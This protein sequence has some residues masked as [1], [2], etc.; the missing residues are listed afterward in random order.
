MQLSLRRVPSRVALLAVLAGVA[1]RA[2][3]D[4]GVSTTATYFHESGGGLDMDVFTP[5]AR[6]RLDIDDTLIVGAGWEADI[7]SG[8]SV[9]IVD[10]PAGA[11]VDVIT[12]AT[13]LT[14]VRH[15][16]GGSLELRGDTT[17]ISAAYTY[18]FEEDYRSHGITLSGRAELFERNTTLEIAWARGFDSACDLAQPRAQEA[19][20]RARLPSSDGC[21]SSDEAE[22]RTTHDID[23][24]TFQ[25]AWTQVWTPVLATQATITA[26]LLHGFQANPYRAVWLGR[27]S[28]QEH[29]P[30]NRARYAL[31]LEARLWIDPLLGAL[32]VFGRVYRDSWAVRSLTAELAWE[33][34][35]GELLRLRAR[36]R[37]Y[38]Q[39][40][41]IFWSD[42]YA[43]DPAGQYFTGDRELS[44]MSSWTFGGRL[45]LGM[46]ADEDGDVLGFLSALDFVFKGDLIMAT[47]SDFH[48]GQVG[49]PNGTAVIFT[50][51]MEA[52]F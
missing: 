25:G 27:T 48:Y 31:G 23:L 32:Q 43:R 13:R 12:S 30:E 17:A 40:G 20:D 15:S 4:S 3:A 28:A 10:A 21:F 52:T 33:Q 46:A 8:A 47:F 7:V 24:N 18:G 37:Y 5:S 39:T 16:F 9:A 50:A 38:T 14:D 34:T 19:V 29:H 42:D 36:G 44:P 11:D 35:I 51:G 1:V 45:T 22:M 2:H 26:Q 6:A 41:A 49:V